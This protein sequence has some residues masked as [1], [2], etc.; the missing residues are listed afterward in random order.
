MKIAILY[1][2]TGKY[3]VFWKDFYESSEKFFLPNEEKHYFVFTDASHVH[4]EDNNRVHKVF[5]EAMEWPYPT[6]LRFDIFLKVREKL[7]TFD[8]AYF[9]NANML[10]VAPVGEEILPMK[11]GLMVVQHPGYYNKPRKKYPYEKDPNSGA[12][13]PETEGKYYAMGGLNGGRADKYLEMI[14]TLQRNIATDL[15]RDV[16]AVW[17]DE[18]HLNRYIIGRDVLVLPPSY[19]FVEEWELPF[20]PKIIIRNKTKWG[21]HDFLRGTKTPSCLWLKL[22]EKLKRKIDEYVK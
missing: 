10:F 16:I 14:E 17:H 1:I 5:Q 7:Q 20:E 15:S 18:S 2:C 8:Y 22:K 19:G 12:F 6:L 9:F 3:D 21:G 11:E 4:A 13:I